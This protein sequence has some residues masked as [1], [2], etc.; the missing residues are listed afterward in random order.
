[1]AARESDRG[2]ESRIHEDGERQ[3]PTVTER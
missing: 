1:V 2:V 3:D